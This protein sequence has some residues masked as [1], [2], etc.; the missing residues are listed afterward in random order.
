M[1]TASPSAC[2]AVF[3]APETRTVFGCKL[4]PTSMSRRCRVFQWTS[5]REENNRNSHVQLFGKLGDGIGLLGSLCS[6]SSP[7]PVSGSMK[8]PL[9]WQGR[10][11]VNPEYS[12]LDF[13]V[14][15]RRCTLW[16]WWLQVIEGEMCIVITIMGLG[17]VQLNARYGVHW[18]TSGTMPL[19]M[20]RGPC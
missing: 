6:C 3:A 14:R 17:I 4:Q 1:S 11:K 2:F 13:A 20:H 15:A 8:H 18:G 9:S 12:F 10:V 16:P 19:K 5:K 7:S